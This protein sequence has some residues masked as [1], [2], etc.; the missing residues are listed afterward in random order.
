MG[1][2]KRTRLPL[3]LVVPLVSAAA[4]IGIAFGLGMVLLE[5]NNEIG[6][7]EA[8][9]GALIVTILIMA[10]AAALGRE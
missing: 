9:I 3:P 7:N 8:I 4:V 5:I 2:V 10:G 1:F 6:E